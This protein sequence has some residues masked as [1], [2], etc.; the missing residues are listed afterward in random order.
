MT[1]SVAPNCISH[2]TPCSLISAK[3]K[4]D[5]DYTSIHTLFESVR[6]KFLRRSVDSSCGLCQRNPIDMVERA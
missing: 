2:C 3:L 6:M 4:Y 1:S 5:T